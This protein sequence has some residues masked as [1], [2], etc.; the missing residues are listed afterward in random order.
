MTSAVITAVARH[1]ATNP[2]TDT[3]PS[4]A[5]QPGH[6]ARMPRRRSRPAREEE[7]G[8]DQQ[9][10]DPDPEPH[11]RA[12]A[13]PLARVV[14]ESVHVDADALVAFEARR[15]PA[16]AAQLRTGALEDRLALDHVALHAPG[17]AHDLVDPAYAL[18]VDAEMDD[19]VDRGRDR[20]YDEPRR[21]VVAR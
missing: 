10:P 3:S 17:D 20:R 2:V 6:A 12:H 4:P 14:E 21:D 1:S 9:Q 11:Q 5:E 18:V 7:G 8:P 13:R 19:Q 16:P 15:H